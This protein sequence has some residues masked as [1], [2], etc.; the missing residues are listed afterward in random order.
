MLDE[1]IGHGRWPNLGHLKRL[2]DAENITQDDY[3]ESWAWIHF[4]IELRPESLAL[5]RDYL[6]ELRSDDVAAPLSERLK[7]IYPNP[8]AALREHV[9]RVLSA[10]SAEPH[11][12]RIDRLNSVRHCS[13]ARQRMIEHRSLSCRRSWR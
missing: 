2:T 10:S 6:G 3:A 4:P 1:S 7:T 9:L 5:L 11:A 8:E 12:E 13:L